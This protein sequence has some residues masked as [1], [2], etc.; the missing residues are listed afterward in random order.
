IASGVTGID[1]AAQALR[2]A[3]GTAT[4]PLASGPPP[5]PVGAAA[6]YIVPCGGSGRISAI[7]GLAELRDGPRVD[8]VVQML[9]PGAVVRPYPDFTGYP[10]FVLSRRADIAGAEEF[11]RFLERSIRIEFTDETDDG[12]GTDA[13]ARTARTAK[14]D[15]TD[16]TDHGGPE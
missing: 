7:H 9:F 13:T 10:A 5:E 1:F 14:T 6:N 4:Q 8:H 15:R 11:H 3:A 16:G 2:I 12:Q